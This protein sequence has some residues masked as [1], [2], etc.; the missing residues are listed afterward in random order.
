[1][2]GKQ[3]HKIMID[4]EP[5]LVCNTS[6]T[7]SSAT[8]GVESPPLVLKLEVVNVGGL[9]EARQ[10]VLLGELLP[11]LVRISRPNLEQRDR[12]R[13]IASSPGE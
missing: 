13:G 8:V 11:S 2:N 1:M 9:C 12:E 3:I 4:C 5:Q 6:C 7:G 10:H